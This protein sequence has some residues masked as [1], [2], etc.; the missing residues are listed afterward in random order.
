MK[1][2]LIY[3][4]LT[5]N[6]ETVAQQIKKIVEESGK[7]LEIKNINQTGTEDIAQVENLLI[8]ASSTWDDGLPCS[9][10]ADFLDENESN[11]PDLSGK[12]LAFFGCGDSNYVQ[13]CKA[14][15]I[16]EEKFTSKNGQ[17]I[18][19]SLKIDGYIEDQSNQEKIK[20]F[21]EQLIQSL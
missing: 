21:A 11:L 5:G 14:V 16:L 7:E 13:F 3:G 8:V 2:L 4:T 1:N 19:S 17:K 9:D 15:D 20:N 6:T 18:T 12:K 10:M